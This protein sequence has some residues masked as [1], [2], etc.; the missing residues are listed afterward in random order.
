MFKI[1]SGVTV[2]PCIIMYLYVCVCCPTVL[3]STKHER[4][5][6]LLYSTREYIKMRCID[7][8]SNKS[9]TKRMQYIVLTCVNCKSISADGDHTMKIE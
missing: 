9:A 4:S 1:I 7:V 8:W 2:F 5:E 6:L 3:L